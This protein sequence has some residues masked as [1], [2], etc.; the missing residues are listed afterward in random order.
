[1]LH[2]TNLRLNSFFARLGNARKADLILFTKLTSDNS[3]WKLEMSNT[4]VDEIFTLTTHALGL[5]WGTLR[6]DK[7]TDR[8]ICAKQPT[9]YPSLLGRNRTYLTQFFRNAISISAMVSR[10]R[11]V[12][13]KAV[14]RLILQIT[15][16]NQ[17]R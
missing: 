9:V 12:R 17:T 14:T 3:V 5:C 15:P 2:L 8:R 4:C 16:L 10:S 6:L 13:K 11:C 7:S 1:M